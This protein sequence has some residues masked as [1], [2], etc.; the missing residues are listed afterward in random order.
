MMKT[1]SR[2]AVISIIVIGI[3]FVIVGVGGAQYFYKHY[4]NSIPEEKCWEVH[5]CHIISD[6]ETLNVESKDE[7]MVSI[8]LEGIDGSLVFHVFDVQYS[9]T[10][11]KCSIDIEVIRPS[12]NETLYRAENVSDE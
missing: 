2:K 3:V 4:L 7:M 12:T 6:N 11:I 8:P 10:E 1:I 9:V 5:K